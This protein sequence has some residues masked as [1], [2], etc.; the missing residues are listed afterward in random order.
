MPM[1]RGMRLLI[2][3]DG[4]VT[5]KG[6]R[7]ADDFRIEQAIPT[8]KEVL[9]RGAHVRIISHRGRP[10][11]IRVASLTQ[12]LVAEHLSKLLKKEIVF[13]KDPL[14]DTA[15]KKLDSSSDILFFENIRF[16]AGEEEN[17]DSFAQRLARWGDAY[18]NEAFANSHRSHASMVALARTLPSYAGIRLEKE[19]AN[20]SRVIN[21]PDHPLV[22]ILGGAKLETKIPLIKRFLTF[23]DDVLIGG[24]IANSLLA[25]KGLPV[26]KSLVDK[27][28]GDIVSL[29]SHK[30]L[31]I[32]IDV[33]VTKSLSRPSGVRCCGVSDVA[34]NEYIVDIG[35]D[36]IAFFSSVIKASSMVVWNGP[37]G[38]AEVPLFANGTTHLAASMKRLSAFKLIGGGD[39]ITLLHSY[40]ALKGFSYVST[41]GGAMLE[42]LAGARMPALDALEG[43]LM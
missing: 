22:A 34:V 7:I 4:D 13:V 37:V 43:P 10:H 31:H 11:G 9:R 26:G 2:R 18:I 12:R 36:T 21:A 6:R 5:M 20:L 25:A 38:L 16:F 19:I 40:G 41:G 3:I 8:I 29:L 23:A 1:Q 24:A 42:F 28:P 30:K 14:S 33:V 32:P 17:D 39:T 27:D 35:P 15:F